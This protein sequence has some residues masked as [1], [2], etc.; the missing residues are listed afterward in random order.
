LDDLIKERNTINY[1]KAQRLS[2]FGHINRMP[3]TGVVKKI[4]KWKVFTGTPVGRPK[5]RR[6]DNVR[7]GMKKIKFINWTGQ[8][9]D[10]LKWKGVV[11]RAKTVRS[12]SA[13]EEEEEDQEYLV[14]GKGGRCVGLTTLP[15]SCADCLETRKP[16]A[17]PACNGI[18]SLFSSLNN[19]T[20]S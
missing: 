15:P 8:V 14:G 1:V 7:N 10:R 17:C 18:A 9:Q 2:L 11:E 16:Q 4:H 19:P 20:V 3:E 5:C 12:C 6:E 13:I